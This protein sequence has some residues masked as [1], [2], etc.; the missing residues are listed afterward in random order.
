MCTE[1]RS[2]KH[3][4]TCFLLHVTQMHSRKRDWLSVDVWFALS[5]PSCLL[6]LSVPY[7]CS[8]HAIHPPHLSGITT[9]QFPGPGAFISHLQQSIATSIYTSVHIYICLSQLRWCSCPVCGLHHQGA[10]FVKAAHH[11]C[12]LC[13]NGRAHSEVIESLNLT[14]PLWSL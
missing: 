9:S 3:K 11:I 7:E 10:N 2:L 5:A 13:D 8:N 12:A 14:P 1:G 4:L 6:S